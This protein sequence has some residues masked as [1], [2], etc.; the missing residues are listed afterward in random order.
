MK[1]FIDGQPLEAEA[2]RAP[3]LSPGDRFVPYA[4]L[5]H[6]NTIPAGTVRR[7]I[8]S[9]PGEDPGSHLV[10]YDYPSAPRE[11]NTFRRAWTTETR[12]YRLKGSV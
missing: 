12:V 7:V 3:A 5:N 2:V 8:D 4:V 11:R 9:F 10:S 6:R 1:A